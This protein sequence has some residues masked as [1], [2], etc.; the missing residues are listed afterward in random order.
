MTTQGAFVINTN[1]CEY[2]VLYFSLYLRPFHTIEH[3]PM[4]IV[5]SIYPI[6]MGKMALMVSI[7][8]ILLP[9]THPPD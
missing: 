6:D 5:A 7:T 1:D 9:M 8:W 3:Q 4:T 2:F